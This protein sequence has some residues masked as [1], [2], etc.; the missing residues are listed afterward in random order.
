MYPKIEPYEHGI[1]DVGEQN[2]VYWE[3]CGNPNGKPALVVHGGPGSERNPYNRR[4]FN[5]DCYKVILFDQRGC[6]RSIPHASDPSTDMNRNTTKHLLSDMERLRERLGIE[7]WLLFGNSWG[8][9][10][11]LAYAEQHPDRVSEIVIHGITTSRRSDIDWLYRGMG[12]IFPAEW[13]RFRNGVA[14]ADRDGDLITAYAHLMAD[15]DPAVR[16]RAAKDW[17][18]WEDV[19]I[20]LEPNVKLNSYSDRPVAALIAFVRICTH[21]W[22]HE[23]WLEEGALLRDAIRLSGIPAALIHGRH[24]LGCPLDTAWELAKKWPN[25][26]LMI[27]NDAGHIGNVTMCE[28][29]LAALDKFAHQ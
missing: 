5:P 28:R 21:Y 3:I 15:A 10:L 19:V 1:L 12:R 24:D 8:S 18:A 4:F 2:S 25:A 11:V 9:T 27:V 13:E 20:S 6:G 17:M 23:S 26:E 16:L 22:A 7:R 29:I 14:E